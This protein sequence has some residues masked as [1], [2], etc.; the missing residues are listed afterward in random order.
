M[1]FFLDPL[2]Q[3]PFATGF[4]YALCLPVLGMYLL[5]HDEWIAAL[6]LAQ[7]SAFGALAAVALHAPVMMGAA[8]A[9]LAAT[10]AKARLGR[11]G[12]TGYVLLLLF[13]WSGALLLVANLPLAD[14]L[15]RALLD[16]QLYFAN[17][18]HLAAGVGAVALTYGALVKLS[19]PLLLE[20][21]LPGFSVAKRKRAR[22]LGFAF[23]LLAA[24]VI[25][26]A[27][28]SVGVMAT[29][30]LLYAPS[31]MAYRLAPDWKTSLFG[32]LATGAA[33]YAAGFALAV[34]LDQPFG[35]VLVLL[36][37]VSTAILLR[38]GRRTAPS[39]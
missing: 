15:G 7:V 31:V 11:G 2:F 38:M 18:A 24:G 17:A 32:A 20:R 19:R 5:L 26:F 28:A 16:G 21:L 3:L 4:A 39:E 9:T 10:L 30:A 36:A 27:T 25:A 35:P 23:D 1:G 37:V 6:A 22:R 33:L 12:A 13:G 14:P 8:A 34:A 29:F